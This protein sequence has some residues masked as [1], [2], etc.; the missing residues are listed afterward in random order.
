MS[1]KSMCIKP[2]IRVS[3]YKFNGSYSEPD[4]LAVPIIKRTYLNTIIKLQS[5]N[6]A[7]KF[8]L[9]IEYCI[10]TSIDPIKKADDKPQ[11][12]E[13]SSYHASDNK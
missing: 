5:R 7:H 3:V 12:K 8:V 10:D 6:R 1:Q 9:W 2:R 11:K 13:E 4:N